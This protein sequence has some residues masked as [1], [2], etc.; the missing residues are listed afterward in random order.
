M[1]VRRLGLRLIAIALAAAW[2]TAAA[3]VLLAYRPGGPLD[4]V[5]GAS[6]TLPLAIATSAVVWPPLARG[7]HS[8]AAMV[9][10]GVGTLL[11]LVPSIGALLAQLQARGTQT[12]IP[13]LEAAYP[14]FLALLG[15][16]L[17][18]GFG[19]AR[20][21]IGGIARRRHRLRIGLGFALALTVVAGAAFT[22][23]AIANEGL[24]DQTLPATASRFGPTSA[25]PDD[26]PPPCDGRLAAGDAAALKARFIGY[27]DGRQI[28]SVD[29]AGQ[30]S[31][32]DFRWLAYVATNRELGQY[33]AARRGVDAWVRT[34]SRGWTSATGASIVGASLDLEATRR[35]LAYSSRATSEDR[36]IELIEGARAR[37][38]RV[39]VDGTAFRATFPQ[40]RWLVGEADLT[41]WRGQLDFWIFL[42]SELGQITGSV[43]GEA[44]AIQADAIQGRIEVRVTAT[45]RD[46]ELVIRAPAR[47]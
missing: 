35:A 11:V 31:G 15:S 29:L 47:S 30:R 13:S 6:M 26:E 39:A 19:L 32:Q 16:S 18:A 12:L 8:H 45:E 46:R 28:G 22:A 7:R 2:A 14:W 4:L 5:V 21:A 1:R 10:L 43:S 23:S 27:V 40:I 24:R 25:G 44:G 36:G 3:F 34:P 20:R 37:R 38:C 41:H 42:D 33:G 9:S 17:F